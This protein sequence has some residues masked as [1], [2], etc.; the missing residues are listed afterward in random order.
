MNRFHRLRVSPLCSATF[1]TARWWCRQRTASISSQRHIFTSSPTTDFR[2]DSS[3]NETWHSLSLWRCS[4]RPTSRGMWLWRMSYKYWRQLT[5]VKPLTWRN[6]LS[7]S[8]SDI[9]PRW[10]FLSELIDLRCNSQV[11]RQNRMET[12]TKELLLDVLHAVADE[13]QDNKLIQ[14]VS[15]C[16]IN[17]DSWYVFPLQLVTETIT[18]FCLQFR[19]YFPE[20]R[21]RKALICR[22]S[23]CRRSEKLLSSLRGRRESWD[24]FSIPTT[25]SISSSP[26]PSSASSS[27]GPPVRFSSH[28]DR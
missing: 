9:S 8:S 12:L 1:T 16:S 6:T 7:T 5:G 21:T 11:A 25:S 26:S 10:G 24:S 17:S 13:C 27:P 2:W 28:Q 3:R 14:D 15:C 22:H 18:Y 19:V 23:A 20:R 4:V